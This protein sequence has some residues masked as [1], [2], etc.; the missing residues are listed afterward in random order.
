MHKNSR[1]LFIYLLQVLC[2]ISCNHCDVLTTLPIL[3][4]TSRHVSRL[5]ITQAPRK[6]L[7]TRVCLKPRLWLAAG[8]HQ[9]RRGQKK[10]SKRR[11]QV[12]AGRA[13]K[14][15]KRL[16]SLMTGKWCAQ[17][18]GQSPAT[19][20][21]ASSLLPSPRP[22]SKTAP[23]SSKVCP[24]VPVVLPSTTA[25]AAAKVAKVAQVVALGKVV[26]LPPVR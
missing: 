21:Q 3:L 6:R 12:A 7:W 17:C 13:A 5:P 9:R 2:L 14:E 8:L 19:S 24:P 18:Q 25:V 15:T 16:W 26:C 1:L 11:R 22:C 20:A 10:K 23:P 4:L